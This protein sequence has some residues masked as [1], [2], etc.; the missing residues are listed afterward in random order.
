MPLLHTPII[1]KLTAFSV[2]LTLS[3]SAMALDF[4]QIQILANQGNAEAQTNLGVMYVSGSEVSQ[5][6]AK[7][8]EWYTKAANQGY[9]VA[10]SNLGVMYINGQGVPQE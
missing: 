9:A 4:E 5:D 10:Q 6:Y 3:L 8:F 7:A 1:R 2:A